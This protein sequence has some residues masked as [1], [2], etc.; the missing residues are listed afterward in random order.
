MTSAPG[1]ELAELI[2]L[3]LIITFSPLSIIPGIVMLFTPRAGPT[4]LAFL[5]GWVTG[6]A[7][8]TVL[9]LT[10]WNASGGLN[11]AA[12][13]APRARIAI[14]AAL[15]ALGLYRW[16]T[17]RRSP[18]A[19]AW[20]RAM[21]GIGPGRAAVTAA[22]LAIVNPKVLFTCAAAGLAIG[23]SGMGHAAA[24]ADVA[25]FT[26]VAAS[27]VALPVLAYAVAGKK[28]DGP[29]IRL[30]NWME[31]RHAALVAV[32]LILIGLVVLCKGIH[33]L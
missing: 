22:A 26:A 30:K 27:S 4:S 2:T 8:L 5:L 3:A 6:I 33:G 25:V 7:G 16:L 9:F 12:A 1:P 20:M 13:W 31:A 17:R 18:H 11:G 28:L 10:V 24:R 32:T 15:I 23:T 21:T 19:P 14:G 29:L